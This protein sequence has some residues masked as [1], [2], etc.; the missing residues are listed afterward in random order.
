MA[1]EVE[2]GE[3]QAASAEGGAAQPARDWLEEEEEA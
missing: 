3:A 1:V 2:G